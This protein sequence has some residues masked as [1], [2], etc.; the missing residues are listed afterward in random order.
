[1]MEDGAAEEE[2]DRSCLWSLG[3]E[4]D[5]VLKASGA[6]NKFSDGK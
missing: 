4:F 2:M 3:K 5:S 6:I 1:M